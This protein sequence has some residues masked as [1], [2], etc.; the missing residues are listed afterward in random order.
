MSLTLSRI[1]TTIRSVSDMSGG[2]NWSKV[3]DPFWNVPSMDAY[4]LLHRWRDSGRLRLLDLGCG[5]GRH[6]LLFA[7]NGFHVTAT[8]V[9]PSGL[10]TLAHSAR[11]EGIPLDIAQADARRLPFEA[12]CF[13]AVLAYHSIYHVD[14]QGMTAVLR[15]LRRVLA[16]AGEVYATFISKTAPSFLDGSSVVVDG[17]VRMKKEE[18]G[19]VLPHYYVDLADL[20]SLL[21]DFRILSLRHVE[22]ILE[23]GSNLH[24]F[25]HLAAG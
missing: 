4:F 15:E 25:A 5:L 22:D 7:R 6:A 3:A 12:G 13:D 21:A 19:S 9:S 16:P 1:P 2:W 10:E 18:E 23:T 24:Y 20:R 17:N 14:R 11:A 8:D